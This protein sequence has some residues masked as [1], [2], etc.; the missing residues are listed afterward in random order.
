MRKLI[1]F[2]GVTLLAV[3]MAAFMAPTT[4]V[5]GTWRLSSFVNVSP[6]ASC[7]F[8]D[9]ITLVQTGTHFVGTTSGLLWCPASFNGPPL[10]AE[11][12]SDS[13]INGVVSGNAITLE[14]KPFTKGT[15]NFALLHFAGIVSDA[16]TGTATWVLTRDSTVFP[17]IG[18]WSAI[19]P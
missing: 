13:V 15:L 11:H 19:Q 18:P 5:T 4:N 3:A 12:I 7:V 16:I 17:L 2:L 1:S 14:F 9:T 6:G 8:N 10:I